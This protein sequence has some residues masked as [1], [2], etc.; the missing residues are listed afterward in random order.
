MRRREFIALLGGATVACPLAARSQQAPIPVIGF[1]NSATPELY[2]RQ[3]SAFRQGLSETGYVEG[4]NVAVELRWAQNQYDRLP[5]LAADLVRRQV[6]VI[7]A[8]NPAALPA[9]AATT[10]IP[11]VFTVGL[12]PVAMGLVE[13][14][15]HP[16][17]NA[18]GVTSLNVE[19]GPKRL[20]VVREA[21]PTATT[22]GLLINP[23]N[24]NAE[25]MSNELQGVAQI[26]GLQLHV[27][28]AS[29]ER[30]LDEAFATL[31]QVR[32]GALLILTDPL[33]IGLSDQLAA[34]A[35]RHGVPTIFQYRGFAVAGGMMSYGGDVS[36]QFR[37]VG[38]Y[39]GRILKGE[40]PADLPVQQATKIELIINLKT[41]KALGVTFP[42]TL[43]GRA[44]EVIE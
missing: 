42:L 15:N 43:L 35:L 41:A 14:R 44:D 29:T 40:K 39:S 23:A 16:G 30:D 28:H 8:N 4:R 22:I 7:A 11:I 6:A 33:F 10:T 27:L 18:T 17:G 25:T 31:V 32:A 19:M 34:L 9:K 13:S 24:P 2:A 26:R 1:L 36:D 20:D 12:G 5:G 3:L 37:Q 21:V 38:V